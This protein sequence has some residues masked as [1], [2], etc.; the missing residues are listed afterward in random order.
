LS[1]DSL[2]IGQIERLWISLQAFIVHID[3]TI[4]EARRF[5]SI[6]GSP[7]AGALLEFVGCIE[8]IIF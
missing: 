2:I 7:F 1:R 6:P 3:G 5:C 4:E 8:E